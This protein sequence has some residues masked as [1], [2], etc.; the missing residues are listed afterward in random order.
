[1]NLIKGEA[2]AKGLVKQLEPFCD[3]I[4]IVGSIRR[5][6]QEVKDIDILLAPKG[7]MLYDLMSKIA[8]LGSED[9][10]KIASKK[11][12]VLKDEVEEVRV[13][14][15]FATV[16]R[17]PVMLLV[18]T[19]GTKSNKKIAVLCENKKWHL[20]VSEGAIFDEDGKKLKIE[21]EEDIYKVLEIPFIEPSWRD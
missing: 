10:I 1:M 12:I 19:G 11:T 21:K 9:G 16:E 7:A 20:S 15:W 4:A 14:L 18:R 2:I 8:E 13:E 5:R 3:R 6:K 17:W